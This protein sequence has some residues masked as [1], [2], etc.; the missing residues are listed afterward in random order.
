MIQSL[1]CSAGC[2]R[3]ARAVTEF[4]PVHDTMNIID[5]LYTFLKVQFFDIFVTRRFILISYNIKRIHMETISL[6]DG[7]MFIM[8]WRY[9]PEAEA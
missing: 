2:A 9:T 7:T 6:I 3:A 4:V 8:Q 5:H 1:E